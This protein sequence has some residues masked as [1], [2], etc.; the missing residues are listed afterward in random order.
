MRQYLTHASK[1]DAG[2]FGVL[3][4]ENQVPICLTLERTFEN[5]LTILPDGVYECTKDY[6]NRGGY[7]TFE[8]QVE[9]HDR[10]LFHKANVETE[11]MGCIGLGFQFGSLRGMPGILASGLAFAHWWDLVR[12]YERF[13]LEIR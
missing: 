8:I 11:L 2:A 12:G 9:G 3:L 7:E 13:E 10:V 4:D 6:F 5:G 1:I